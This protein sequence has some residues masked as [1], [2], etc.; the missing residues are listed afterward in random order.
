MIN[1]ESD[2]GERMPRQT[3]VVNKQGG[4]LQAKP[5]G[6][7][8]MPEMSETGSSSGLMGAHPCGGGGG[9]VRGGR[10]WGDTQYAESHVVKDRGSLVR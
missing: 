6:S 9:G 10:G 5:V 1:T 8:E 4:R 3:E 7:G 2:A